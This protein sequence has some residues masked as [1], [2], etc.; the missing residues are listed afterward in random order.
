MADIVV[1]G[2]LNMDLVVRTERMPRPGETVRG[3]DLAMVPGGKGANQAA[4]AARLGAR[5][6]MIGRVGSDAFGMSL[7]DNMRNQGVGMEH[8]ARDAKATTGTAMI[9]VDDRGENSIVVAT[10]ANDRVNM[11]DVHAA[12]ALFL[13][14]T[15]CA[16]L[17]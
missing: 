2:S 5:V 14:W 9:I 1:L 17:R 12:R 6:E 15:T 10:G 4:A 8:V 11:A 7:L 13:T 16:S 3:R